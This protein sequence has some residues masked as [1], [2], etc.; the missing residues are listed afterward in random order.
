VR[1]LFLLLLAALLSA[2][3]IYVWRA[4]PDN[5]VNFWF[6]LFTLSIDSWVLGIAGVE[7]GFNTEMYGRLTFVGAGF[8]PPTFLAFS[9]VFPT[10]SR[11]PTPPVVALALAAALA[12]GI[13]SV[14]TPWVAHGISRTTRGIQRSAGP[15]YPVF[16]LYIISCSVT[17]VSVFVWK[18]RRL[19]G[20]ARAQLQ[21]LGIGILVIA[22]GGITS[23]LLIP[24]TT[25]SSSYSGLGPYFALPLVLLVAHS[26]I[27]HRLMDIRLVVNRGLTYILACALLSTVVIALTRL[28]FF[29]A[30]LRPEP[31]DA[32]VVVIVSLLM[33]TIPGQR[34]I[35][36]LIDPYLYRR[37]LDHTSALR[38]ATHRL[39]RLMQ[40][41]EL[42]SELRSFLSQSFLPDSFAMIVRTSDGQRL[43]TLDRGPAVPD[44]LRDLLDALVRQNTPSVFF[45][46]APR[47]PRDQRRAHDALREAGFELVITLGRRSQLFGVILLGPRKSGD[48]YFAA[49]LSFIESLAELT[50]IAL[51]NSLLYKQ[52]IQMLEYSDRLLEAI[53]SAVLAVDVDGRITSFNAAAKALLGLD[54]DSRRSY[55]D[56]L[57]SQI[58]WALA[59]AI[60]NAWRPMEVEA[61]IDHATR[62]AVPVIL[63]TAVFHDEPPRVSGALVV[64]TD[65]STVKALERNQRRVEHLAMMARFY[66]GIAHEIRNPLAAISNFIAML[67]DRFDD[68]EY[69]DTA[70]RLLPMEVGRIVGLADRLRLMAPSEGG[71][72]TELSLPPLLADIIAIHGPAAEEAGCRLL[73][74]CPSDTPKI[75]A[76]PGQLVQLFVNL[77]KNAAESMPRGGDITVEVSHRTSSN[78]EGRLL[79]RVTDDGV[80]IDPALRGRIFEP[81]FTTKPSGTGLGLSICQEIADFHRARLI[82]MPRLGR[83]GTIAQ[84]EFPYI[85][86][87]SLAQAL[88][89]SQQGLHNP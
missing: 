2:L 82:L 80:G 73:L 69:R 59:L 68:P 14:T 29:P 63:S 15:L 58:A 6:G 38:E 85:S 66:A 17:A 60:T 88:V 52:R 51:E 53:D 64:V 87:D 79:V 84:I 56:I 78:A 44:K 33:L 77:F 62:G 57:P 72:L 30:R 75:A 45:V 39:S 7:S 25:G 42:A 76:D 74:H 11:W 50:S 37:R 32:L 23:N 49:D 13:L 81:F 35:E 27:R 12:F 70:A 61:S 43:E 28:V 4:R 55:L 8:I 47:V 3:A 22:A 31:Q 40:P 21:Y 5:P 20:L 54:D 36:R 1:A 65:L 48:A 18:A 67:P 16:A 10:T 26:I 71:K 19:R 34:F 9:R 41:S 83:N 24:L 86:S 46:S 89:G